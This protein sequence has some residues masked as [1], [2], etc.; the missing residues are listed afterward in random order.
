VK[1]R[2]K[3]WIVCAALVVVLVFSVLAVLN[4]PMPYKF[5]ENSKLV[6]IVVT[7]RGSS[8]RATYFYETVDPARTVAAASASEL[9]PS[10][11]WSM[12]YWDDMAVAMNPV[13][14]ERVTFWPTAAVGTGRPQTVEIEQSATMLDRFRAWAF[15][16]L[17]GRRPVESDRQQG[18]RG[19]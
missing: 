17:H 3:I 13:L 7:S 9:L 11:G 4:R 2:K 8:N 12:K 15:H 19:G 18:G 14:D 16:V 5:L 1:R 10:E 6:D